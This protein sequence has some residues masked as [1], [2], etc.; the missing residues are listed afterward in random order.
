MK[1]EGGRGQQSLSLAEGPSPVNTQPTGPLGPLE[2]ANPHVLNTL[3][4]RVPGVKGVVRTHQL[5]APR[6]SLSDTSAQLEEAS[7]FTRCAVLFL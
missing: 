1:V 3:T 7:A 4:L 5:P 2:L 6:L